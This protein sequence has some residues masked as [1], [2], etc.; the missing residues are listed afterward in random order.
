MYIKRLV[1]SA[2][3]LLQSLYLLSQ[4]IQGQVTDTTQKPLAGV[5]IQVL[6]SLH[7][8]VSDS[9]GRFFLTLPAGAFVIKTTG[10]GH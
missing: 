9:N 4:N 1:L 5:H 10:L 6:N 3:A 8:A 2:A 7:S